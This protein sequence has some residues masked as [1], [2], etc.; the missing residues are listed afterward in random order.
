[1]VA[2]T[3]VVAAVGQR[4]TFNTLTALPVLALYPLSLLGVEFLENSLG[5]K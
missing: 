2:C 5:W 1:M 3:L 4:S